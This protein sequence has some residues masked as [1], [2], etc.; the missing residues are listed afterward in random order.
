MAHTETDLD[1][2]NPLHPPV[3]AGPGGEGVFRA[4]YG[5]R[6]VRAYTGEP[7][8]KEQIDVL[9]EA[10]VHAPSAVNAQPWA[11]VVIQ[12]PELLDRYAGQAKEVLLAEPPLIEVL[13]SGLPDLDHLRELA[14]TPGYEL[15][16]G[17]GTLVVVFSTSIG[18]VPDCFLAA[19]NLMLAAWGLG[20]G[21]CPIGLAT[22]LFNRAEVKAELGVSPGWPAA[23]PIVVGHPA[24]ETAATK[25]QPPQVAAW[26]RA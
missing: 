10:A 23:L 15:F 14:S 12:D 5:R 11:F 19:E 26:R 8:A 17:A 24:G 18:G 6:A 16:H 7:V 13:N 21:T 4:I 3:A 20:L 9:L 22:P 2:Q 25:R 1:L